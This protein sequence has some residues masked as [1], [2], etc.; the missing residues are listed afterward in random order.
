[1]ARAETDN[2]EL[3]VFLLDVDHFKNYND[4]SGH[5]AGDEILR[6]LTELVVDEVRADDLFG[7]FG[8]EEFLLVLPGRTSQIA[9]YVAEQ[10]RRRIEPDSHLE[11]NPTRQAD[12]TISEDAKRTRRTHIAQRTQAQIRRHQEVEPAAGQDQTQLARQRERA[13]QLQITTE[14]RRD[15]KIVGR[16]R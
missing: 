16:I 7:R 12:S 5:L 8:G 3:S 2:T 10:I 11:G 6:R 4:R 1:M 9:G 15:I 14:R 13:Q